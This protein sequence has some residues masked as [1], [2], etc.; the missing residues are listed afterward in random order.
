MA[1][2]FWVC[3]AVTLIYNLRWIIQGAN[4]VILNTSLEFENNGSRS[5]TAQ[6]YAK[7][8]HGL[9]SEALEILKP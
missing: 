5:V 6:S 2:L 3:K 8:G 7:N 9:A 4:S 1:F